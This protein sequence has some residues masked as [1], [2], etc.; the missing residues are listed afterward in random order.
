MSIKFNSEKGLRD[1]NSFEVKIVFTD[2]PSTNT[3]TQIYENK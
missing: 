2:N 1:T 3:L